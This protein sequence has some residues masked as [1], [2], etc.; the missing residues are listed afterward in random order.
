MP[1]LDTFRIGRHTYSISKILL[2]ILVI[3]FLVIWLYPVFLNIITA[4]KPDKELLQDPLAL[5]QHPSLKAFFTAWKYTDMGDLLR[6]SF[7]IAIGSVLLGIVISSIPAY[8]FSRFRIPGGEIIFLVLLM[9]LM[10]PQQTVII[11]LY[12]V[13]NRIH[14]LDSFIG[15][16]IVHAAYGM[17]FNMFVMRGFMSGIPKEL[18]SAARVDGCSDF[19]VFRYVIFPLSIPAI[20]V[21]A[22]LNFINI[23]N[24]F[25]F[26]IILIQSQGKFPIT[27]GLINIQQSQYFSSWNIP[28]AALI[29]A[30]IPTI[31]MYILAHRYITEG[32]LAGAVKG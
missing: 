26:A 13:L 1:N 28:A 30:Q 18:E 4:L 6:N 29:M 9:T 23:W 12:D 27:V 25:F 14:L 22:S 10:L 7:V 16:I 17:P 3:A 20:A 19:D 2:T 32:V 31:I 21:A 15:I 24:E 8:A 11:S 5:P